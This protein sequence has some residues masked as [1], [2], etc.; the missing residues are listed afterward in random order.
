MDTTNNS[1][2]EVVVFCHGGCGSFMTFKKASVWP[3]DFFGCE[4][5]RF[6]FE[7]EGVFLPL[8]PGKIRTIT[9]YRATGFYRIRDEWPSQAS[10]DEHWG[11][12]ECWARHVAAIVT[13]KAALT[14]RGVRIIE[15]TRDL[16]VW[17][18][19]LPK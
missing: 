12:Y 18:E 9:E 16:L 7:C 8:T 17:H 19:P 6:G 5:N 13:N 1:K 15:T 2:D 10:I 4:K 11:S 3:G 14:S